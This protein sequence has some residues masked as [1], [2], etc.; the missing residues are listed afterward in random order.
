M[1]FPNPQTHRLGHRSARR[2]GM[3][4]QARRIIPR[5]VAAQSFRR[6]IV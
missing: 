1:T 6:I 3:G 5:E 2:A 4:R